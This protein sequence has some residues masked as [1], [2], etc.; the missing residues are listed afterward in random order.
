M[1]AG[2]I[3]V[4]ILF[5]LLERRV[6]NWLRKSSLPSQSQAADVDF[7]HP[8][9]MDVRR[10]IYFRGSLNDN[11]DSWEDGSAPGSELGPVCPNLFKES[12]QYYYDQRKACSL[13]NVHATDKDIFWRLGT[14]KRTERLYSNVDNSWTVNLSIRFAKTFPMAWDCLHNTRVWI[15]ILYAAFLVSVFLSYL[16]I[17]KDT[18]LIVKIHPFLTAQ[19]EKLPFAMMSAV[20]GSLIIGQMANVMTIL[21]FEGWNR[22]QKALASVLILAM[23][24]VVNYKIYRLK[25]HLH[26]NKGVYAMRKQLKIKLGNL[27]LLKNK[28]RANENAIEHLPQLVIVALLILLQNS[29]TS[30]IPPHLSNSFLADQDLFL[31]AS[32][33]VSFLSLVRGQFSLAQAHKRGFIPLIGKI[34]L[35]LYFTICSAVRVVAIILFYAPSLGL[36]DMLFHRK[37]GLMEA[38]VEEGIDCNKNDMWSCDWN[39]NFKFEGHRIEE[40]YNFPKSLVGCLVPILVVTHLI[41][42]KVLVDKIF[43][44]GNTARHSWAREVME[45]L[46]TIVCPPVHLD[47]ELIHRL[48]RNVPI[49]ECW[50]RS[51]MLMI[52]LHLLNVIEHFLLLMPLMAL[53]TAIDQRN[54]VLEV[55]FPPTEDEQY[56]TRVVDLI[57]FSA[58]GGYPLVTL[59][60]MYLAQSYFVRGHAW[61]R[62]LNRNI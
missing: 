1:A 54:R 19:H 56:S 57:L 4:A 44:K 9:A 11:I 48:D 28:M 58:I 46:Y 61:S 38:R 6:T 47:W 22:I 10:S 35:L 55:H 32:A 20:V 29:N 5:R 59:C 50:K 24:A 62:I 42:S 30:T 2:V 21:Y 25:S 3:V 13:D 51:R 43:Y 33:L 31:F 27:Q 7:D 23:P 36:M 18:F 39:R 15:S 40:F 17:V 41:L 26:R 12:C 45:G 37:L 16:D 53:K 49:E 60:S 14:R 34:I 52:A 8:M